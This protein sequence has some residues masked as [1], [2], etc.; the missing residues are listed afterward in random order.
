[1]ITLFK[2]LLVI[3]FAAHIVQSSPGSSSNVNNTG[4]ISLQLYDI[5][6]K[7]RTTLSS[8]TKTLTMQLEKVNHL[9][10][11][12]QNEQEKLKHSSEVF[13][14][15]LQEMSRGRIAHEIKNNVKLVKNFVYT[16]KYLVKD[17]FLDEPVFFN[18][19]YRLALANYLLVNNLLGSMVKNSMTMTPNSFN[20]G[21]V[22]GMMASEE[23]FGTFSA[24]LAH[25]MQVFGMLG[26]T[27][28]PNL[29]QDL[30]VVATLDT[31]FD[32][33]TSLVNLIVTL[34]SVFDKQSD[35]DNT[36]N[37]EV[38]A[39]L[40]RYSKESSSMNG[41][42]DEN[43][44]ETSSTLQEK[45]TLNDS[46]DVIQ[47]TTSNLNQSHT[48]ENI[49][50]QFH[51]DVPSANFK[52]AVFFCESYTSTYRKSIDAMYLNNTPYNQLSNFFTNQNTKVKHYLRHSN[53]GHLIDLYAK[54]LFSYIDVYGTLTSC[55]IKGK[56]DALN[57]TETNW[58]ADKYT[59]LSKEY[60][61]R[62]KG[63]LNLVTITFMH[64]DLDLI[65]AQHEWSKVLSVMLVN[66]EDQIFTIG[67]WLESMIID[68]ESFEAYKDAL[69]DA[70]LE[71][72]GW[73]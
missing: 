24:L 49:F 20:T 11:M 60:I 47:N 48:L 61:K 23:T 1:M 8:T 52:P 44:I 46:N 18:K 67:F 29:L 68:R 65:Q 16:C 36:P 53:G 7:H 25:L 19:Y 59:L 12:I 17:A 33:E 66:I 62:V 54:V 51:T 69:E 31:W 56:L 45:E 32:K 63:A 71:L 39:S 43:D 13:Q 22:L 15:D 38:L 27:D 26:V 6:D 5:I 50:K 58:I 30:K 72:E 2:V 34:S 14:R 35:S 3:T 4:Q 10:E 28:W 70:Y 64:L 40:L 37:K 9:L 21:P 55:T 41:F 57:E 42:R 73:H